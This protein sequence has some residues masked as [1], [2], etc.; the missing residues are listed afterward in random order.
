MLDQRLPGSGKSPR[1]LTTTETHASLIQSP[2]EVGAASLESQHIRSLVPDRNSRDAPMSLIRDMKHYILGPEKECHPDPSDDIVSKGIISEE[3]TLTLLAGYL[4]L[5]VK[6]SVTHKYIRFSQLSRRWLFMRHKPIAIRQTSPLLFASCTL[7]GLH[8]IR[9]L[10]GSELH[11]ALYKHISELLSK[12][13]LI[14]P[15]SLETIQSLLVLS[16]WNLVPN[17]DTEHVNGWLLSGMAAMHG[18]LTLNFEQLGRSQKDADIDLKS[19]EALRSW[20]LICLCH[21]Q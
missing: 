17:K 19:R 20:N 10:H 7:A 21:L 13:M 12:S 16:M 2:N 3:L 8:I 15:L 14:S 18:M 4:N 9:S 11:Q 6:N 5:S 1:P